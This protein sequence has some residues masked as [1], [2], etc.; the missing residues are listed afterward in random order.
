MAN[1]TGNPI[2]ST[3]VKD[4]KDNAENFDKFSNGAAAS[5]L[6][7]LG[8]LRKSVAGM[9]AEFMAEQVSRANTFISAQ[10]AKQLSFDAAQNA[11]AGEYSADK[12][13]RD[14]LYASDKLSR[15]SVFAGDQTSRNTLFVTAQTDRSAQFNAMMAAT[16]YEA[17]IPYAAGIV[18]DRV[19][20]TV[21]NAG[22]VYRVL[23][24]AMPFTTSGVF[25]T[26]SAKLVVIGDSSLQQK[27]AD[28][29]D[30]LK[31]LGLLGYDPSL[32]Y[33]ANTAGFGL[34]HLTDNLGG[35]LGLGLQFAA[36]KTFRIYHGGTSIE[37]NSNS[38][39]RQFIASL[40]KQYGDSGN[41]VNI[42]GGLGGGYDTAWSGWKKQPFG[43]V[44]FTR[45]RGDTS[46]TAFT[47]RGYG[48][49]FTLRY[50]TEADGGSFDV[51]IDGVFSRAI[52][53]N[54]VQS[55]NN[56][57]TWT[58]E[59]GHHTIEFKPP[60]SGYAYLETI[61]YC[62][63]QNGIQMFDASYG[64]SS[65]AN[66]TT[67]R[68]PV[69]A[70][71]AGVPIVGYS[72]LD[73][74][75]SNVTPNYKPD[76]FICGWTVNDAGLGMGSF[77]TAYKP[78]MDRIVNTTK[79]LNV[80][81]L[82]IIEMG[83][84]YTMPSDPGYATYKAI[85]SLLRSYASE[86]H[87][88]VLD[89][90]QLSGGDTL[91]TAK[92]AARYY[93]T[94]V[95]D[96][97]GALI[98]GDFTHCNNNGYGVLH[99]RLCSIGGVVP[100]ARSG[101]TETAWYQRVRRVGPIVPGA[102][103]PY[104]RQVNLGAQR[105]ETNSLGLKYRYDCIG[106]SSNINAPQ[107]DIVPLY[108]SRNEANLDPAINNLIAASGTSDKYGN[109]LQNTNQFYYMK[110]LGLPIVVG[111]TG[112]FDITITIVIGAG[113]WVQ[114]CRD[115]NNAVFLEQFSKGVSIGTPGQAN[116]SNATDAPQFLHYTIRAG[117][118]FSITSTGKIY[119]VYLTP[120]QFPCIPLR[121]SFK[122]REI[123]AATYMVGDAK[124]DKVQIG[125]TYLE[126][127]NGKTVE[128]V[129]IGQRVYKVN[130]GKFY[131]LYR[132]QNRSL[133][134]LIANP[135]LNGTVTLDAYSESF[136]GTPQVTNAASPMCT[137]PQ[138]AWV[139]ESKYT[140]TGK[141]AG[142]S[143]LAITMV[144]SSTNTTLFYNPA[145]N[146]WV[147]TGGFIGFDVLDGEQFAVTMTLPMATQLAGLPFRM[148]I[149]Q[150]GGSGSASKWGVF[151]LVDG[152]SA[153]V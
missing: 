59:E 108:S 66:M 35:R 40:T 106:Y 74:M 6:D 88:T 91:T 117:G 58:F 132:V 41:S 24:S 16:T 113:A 22:I 56:E 138:Q 120:T 142:T 46:S 81:L 86:A 82:I 4:L 131:G 95:F 80:P 137:V 67:I 18:L 7:R 85:R 50:S 139:A 110:P 62:L 29:T 25:A 3:S 133:A 93:P 127:V 115:N 136:G 112:V 79:T 102:V 123:G 10:T 47:L 51:W 87:V 70:Q 49:R 148:D 54:G 33:A 103:P 78:S 75:F 68:T 150:N 77:N 42:L 38:A 119:A 126:T 39:T 12:A 20:K 52:N 9:N 55:V 124:S 109:Y 147:S 114:L 34:N 98:G 30:L 146:L 97:G 65:I 90:H 2:G 26:D 28:S 48:S 99:Q 37:N 17:P 8:T 19:T 134:G 73:G 84:H 135:L 83:G 43:G 105:L 44:A 116:G 71:V 60:A 15:D 69:G 14:A 153:C 101:E 31:G 76:L 141:V 149:R 5:Y 130:D 94:A 64:G 152:S 121:E 27:L 96:G 63:D 57:S 122:L 92:F 111:P 104:S 151:S 72:A 143:R 1:N 23:A 144:N 89:W 129:C 118:Q 13:V 11:R 36:G 107:R 125:Q 100:I 53:C 61:D 140:L 145:T 128:K 21:S 32:D 45:L